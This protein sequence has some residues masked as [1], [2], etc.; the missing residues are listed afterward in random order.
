MSFNSESLPTY[1]RQ[2]FCL[3]LKS[4][5]ESRGIT[6][7]AIAQATKIPAYMFAALERND[8]RRWP[9]G[10][11]RRSFFRDYARM[12]GV[13]VAEACAEFVRLFPDDETSAPASPVTA[14]EAI[15][16]K[17]AEDVRL[18][19]DAGW[20][21]PGTSARTRLLI[22]LL[23]ATAIVVAAVIAWMAGLERPETT[24]IVGLV[25]FF[26]ATVLLGESPAKWA[27]SKRQSM[28][29]TLKQ[30]PSAIAGAWGRRVDSFKQL[31]ERTHGSA[32]QVD[33]SE[34]R[35]WITDAHNVGPAPSNQLRVRIK[36]PQ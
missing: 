18:V 21:A 30:R 11:F 15:Q 14:T 35:E 34:P 12:I 23:D 8:L 33:E 28:L 13:P 2:E 31:F 3:S 32:E 24:A 27:L 5:R 10:L 36:V 7:A 16:A 4:A 19:L 20:H 26:L 9:K 29:E 17:Q 1:S 25:Y 22:A 6:L